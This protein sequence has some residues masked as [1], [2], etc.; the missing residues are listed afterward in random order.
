M[1]CGVALLQ[2]E[3]AFLG[4]IKSNHSLFPKDYIEDKLK[5]APGCTHILLKATYQDVDLIAVG[6]RYSSKKLLHFILTRDTG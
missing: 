2:R 5:D 3:R 4:Q 6:Y 1:R